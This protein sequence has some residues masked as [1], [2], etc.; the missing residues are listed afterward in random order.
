VVVVEVA[1]VAGVVVVVLVVVAGVE[2]PVS[3][4]RAAAAKQ[5]RMNFFI[6]MIFVWFVT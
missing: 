6:N 4:A 3:D 5:E 2:Q 1:G